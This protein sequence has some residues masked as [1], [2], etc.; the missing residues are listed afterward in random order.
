MEVS[1]AGYG[2]VIVILGLTIFGGSLFV[3][4]MIIKHVMDNPANGLLASI[5]GAFL[6]PAIGTLAAGYF[7][8]LVAIGLGGG[9][10]FALGLACPSYLKRKRNFEN[11]QIENEIVRNRQT[12]RIK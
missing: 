2:I 5:F 7:D 9:L 8:R 12:A 11:P 4:W 6:V 3:E 1:I 10:L